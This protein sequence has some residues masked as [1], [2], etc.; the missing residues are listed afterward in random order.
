MIHCAPGFFPIIDAVIRQADRST[1]ALSTPTHL[2][3]LLSLSLSQPESHT[4]HKRRVQSGV[5]HSDLS[6]CVISAY[7]SFSSSHGADW[8]LPQSEIRS[9]SRETFSIATVATSKLPGRFLSIAAVCFPCVFG[10]TPQ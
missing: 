10:R 3:T 5:I 1:V 9:S 6:Q 4:N 2:Q 7:L 8:F